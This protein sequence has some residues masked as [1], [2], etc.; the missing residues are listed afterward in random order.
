MGQY[1]TAIVTQQGQQILAEAVGAQQVITFTSVKTSSHSYSSETD[2][3][4]LTGLQDIMQSVSPSSAAVTNGNIV[5]VT[6]RFDNAGVQNEYQIQTIGL[7]GKTQNGEETL[8]AV[9]KA[10]TPDTMPDSAYSPI[11]YIYNIQL[12]IQSGESVAVTVNPAGTATVQDVLK[13]QQTIATLQQNVNEQIAQL[14]SDLN[15]RNDVSDLLAE[16]DMGRLGKRIVMCG[17]NTLN[18]PYKVGLTPGAEGVAYINMTNDNYG[19][20]LFITS[21]GDEVFCRY[22][23]NG[24]WSPEWSKLITSAD[25]E[26][27]LQ[28]FDYS[29]MVFDF[30]KYDYPAGVYRLGSDINIQNGPSISLAYSVILVIRYPQQDTL[31]MIGFPYKDYGTIVFRQASNSGWTSSGWYK[32]EGTKI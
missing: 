14:N 13:L 21:G 12:T 16:A 5:E 1:N 22:K 3:T 31:A 11:A 26:D 32:I 9:V 17:M 15:S 10:V 6:A 25:M 18:T 27:T 19:T 7:Y 23:N 2:L 20:I 4:T 24:T 28:I 8:I 29:G 30:N